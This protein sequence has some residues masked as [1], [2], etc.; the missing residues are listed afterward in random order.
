MVNNYI[1]N[2]RDIIYVNF[3]PQ[4][5]HEQKR[6][7]PVIVLSNKGFNSFTKLALVCPI[8]FNSKEFPLHVKLKNTKKIIGVV[9][10]EQIKTI[11]F[12]ARDAKFVERL[13]EETY[14][15]IIEIL[16]SFIDI[17]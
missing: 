3:N 11:D 2:Q 4:S 12:M 6:I 7:R 5:G 1:P 17:E 16:K 10:V 15:E 9:M 8:T 13:D 14:N